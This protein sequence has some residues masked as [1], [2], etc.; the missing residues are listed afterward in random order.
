MKQLE[1]PKKNVINKIHSWVW[2]IICIMAP[3]SGCSK[4]NPKKITE[5]QLSH[6]NYVLVGPNGEWKATI[7][8]GTES[9]HAQILGY[10]NFG[11]SFDSYG[12]PTET[13]NI[14]F[15]TDKGNT[16]AIDSEGKIVTKVAK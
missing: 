4:S 5:I 7:T 9:V 15:I 12:K 3:I 6:G 1:K 14:I 16:I 8:C 2:F 13:T 11:V 10:N